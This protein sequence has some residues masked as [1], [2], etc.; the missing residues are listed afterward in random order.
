MP[1]VDMRPDFAV[2][3]SA[4]WPYTILSLGNKEAT[5]LFMRLSCN[6]VRI[7]VSV[8]TT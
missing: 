7:K 8:G 2:S 3:R 6:K 1:T 5:R 4:E